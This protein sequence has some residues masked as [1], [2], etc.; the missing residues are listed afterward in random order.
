MRFEP[1]ASEVKGKCANHLATEA[2][3]SPFSIYDML[4]LAIVK[5]WHKVMCIMK[6]CSILNALTNRKMIKIVTLI[7]LLIALTYDC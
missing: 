7:D 6:I 2:P 5:L 4:H 1:A 3:L